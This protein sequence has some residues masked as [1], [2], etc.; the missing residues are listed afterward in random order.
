MLLED[1]VSQNKVIDQDDLA[2]DQQLL[3]EVQA[4]LKALGYYS[5][6]IDGLDGPKTQGAIAR[7]CEEHYL[8]NQSVG[9]YG[10]GFAKALL[11][12]KNTG[13]VTAAQCQAIFGRAITDAQLADL[14]SCLHRFEINTKARICQFLAQLGAESGGLQWM[15]ELADGSAY[16]G[17][18]DLGNTQKGWGKLYKG[19]G[20]LQVTGRANYEAL[21]HYLGDPKVLE[22]GCNYVAEHLPFTA[23]GHW[24]SRNGLNR[25]ID[26][27]AT[28]RQVSA[29]VNGK[30]PANGLSQ[31]EMY[32]QRACQ[33]IH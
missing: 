11:E 20:C 17:R 14:N 18:R 15:K 24:W 33:A 27:G 10:A 1:I 30:D 13:L 16:E 32:Y 3:R 25:L 8:N 19:A 31:R 22:L 9:K 6:N 5:G 4:K 29:R 26:N 21:A 7:F 12:A 28:C 23:S 2:A